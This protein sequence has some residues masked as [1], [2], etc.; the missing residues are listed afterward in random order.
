M[1]S[2]LGTGVA[3][4]TPFSSDGTV[5]YASLENLVNFQIDNGVDYLVVLGTTA[6]TATLSVKEKEFIKQ[7]VVEV[8]KGRLPLVLGI[9]G[10]NTAAIVSEL[11]TQDLS[12][13]DAILSVSPYYN[14]PSQEGVFQHFKKIA[15]VSPKPL[16]VYNVPGRTSSNILPETILRLSEASDTIIGVKEA[17]GDMVQAIKLLQLV[18]DDFLVISGDDMIALPMTLAGGSGVISVLGQAYPKAF[19]QMIDLGL[20]GDAKKAY[21]HYYDLLELIDLIFE[22]GNP[23]GI[24]ALL[25]ELNVIK[26]GDKVRL[27]L[28]SATESLKEKIRSFKKALTLV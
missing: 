28:V 12:G 2:F 26:N 8:N 27:P 6:E 16:I 13:Y 18:P 20:Q 4:A 17:A 1:K 19:S 15:E 21:T 7:K 23:V 11:Q 9:G 10:N 25:A 3:L 5:D 22:E 24:K 14:K